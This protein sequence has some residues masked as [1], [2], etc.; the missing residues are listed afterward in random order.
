[1]RAD[2]IE[3]EVSPYSFSLFG[4]IDQINLLLWVRKPEDCII[5]T[6]FMSRFRKSHLNPAQPIFCIIYVHPSKLTDYFLTSFSR[7]RPQTSSLDS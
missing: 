4:L 6:F 5:T 3:G 2:V 1:M 7:Y